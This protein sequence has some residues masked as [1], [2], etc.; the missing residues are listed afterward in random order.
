[1]KDVKKIN[2]KGYDSNGIYSFIEEEVK[3]WRPREAKEK[4][5]YV[6]DIDV[7][8]LYRKDVRK[9]YKDKKGKLYAETYIWAGEWDLIPFKLERWD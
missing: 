3:E 1:M 5:K 8:I 2:I 4:M 9:V 6:G 7:S